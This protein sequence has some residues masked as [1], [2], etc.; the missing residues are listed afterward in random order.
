[1]NPNSTLDQTQRMGTGL[2]FILFP[3]VFVFAFAVHPDLLHPRLLGPEELALRAHGNSLLQFGHVL[4][5][6]NTALLVVVA[7]H[8]MKIVKGT[9]GAWAGYV[10]GAIAILG[11]IA[12]AADKGALCLTMSALDT[13]PQSVFV[14]TMPGVLAMFT[15]QGWLVLLWGIVLLPVG[16]AIQAVA[17]LKTRTLPRWQA[18]LFLVAVLLV[19]TPDGLEIVNLSASM[20]MAVSLVPYGLQIITR[21]LRSAESP[22]ATS[23]LRLADTAPISGAGK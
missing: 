3:L 2:A 9:A 16:F 6:A 5:T 15:K 17:L 22:S 20:L 14:Q 7:L 8:F 18:S 12:L 19:A 4:V 23:G 13:V 10:G 1:M 21:A 11:A